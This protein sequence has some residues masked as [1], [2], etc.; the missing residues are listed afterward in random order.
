[1]EFR[2]FFVMALIV[3]LFAFCLISFSYNL[4]TQNNANL[5]ILNEPSFFANNA[6]PVVVKI[7]STVLD[8]ES[9]KA[10]CYL[11]LK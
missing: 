10:T 3:G 1:M 9:K 6:L 5:T 2:D 7:A 8:T 4:S 11:L